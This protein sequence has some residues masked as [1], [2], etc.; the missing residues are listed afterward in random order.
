MKYITDRGNNDNTVREENWNCSKLVSQ[1]K[2]IIM[3]VNTFLTT[4]LKKAD[5]IVLM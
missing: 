2:M 1:F 5:D 4:F 3:K